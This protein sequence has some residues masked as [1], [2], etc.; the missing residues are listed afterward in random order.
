M[1]EKMNAALE[2]VQDRYLLEAEEYEKKQRPAWLRL[3]AAAAVVALVIGVLAFWP[4]GEKE[5]VTGPGLLTIRAYAL[6]ENE[7]SDINS[8]VLEEGVELPWEYVWS[9]AINV[10]STGLPIK[11]EFPEAEFE[12][13]KIS[14]EVTVSGGSVFGESVRLRDPATGKYYWSDHPYLGATFTIENNSTLYW[15]FFST[16]FHVLKNEYTHGSPFAR[17]KSYLDIIIRADDY[18]V[19]YAV[20]EIYELPKEEAPAFRYKARVLS[21]ISF[22]QVEGAYQVISRKDVYNKM[23]E[24]HAE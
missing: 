18:I 7:I 19:G 6:N 16:K 15:Q 3:V 21:I 24:T 13:A 5:Y 12:G 4:T 23:N 20:V 14:L 17:G 11:L 22:P 8:T 9:P 1:F 10:M 2:Q